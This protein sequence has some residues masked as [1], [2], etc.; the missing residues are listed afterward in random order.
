MEWI[1]A[2]DELPLA[3]NLTLI[4]TDNLDPFL[5]YLDENGSWYVNCPRCER[6]EISDVKYWSEFHGVD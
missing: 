5:G 3:T 4:L 2:E 6:C 1:D